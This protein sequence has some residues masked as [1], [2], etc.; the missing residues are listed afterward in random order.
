MLRLLGMRLDIS[1]LAASA[2][3]S[4]AALFMAAAV[5]GKLI[6]AW[7]PAR[8]AGFN[9]R[10]WL[11]I[12]CGLVP[13]GEL[14]LAVAT[15]ALFSGILVP[16][17]QATLLLLALT[18]LAIANPLLALVFGSGGHGSREP[19]RPCPPQ[20]L[21][22][23]FAT[24]GAPRALLERLIDV[25]ETE[26]FHVQLLNRHAA[27]YQLGKDSI[28]IGLRPE[29]NSL[30]V[31]CAEKDQPLINNAM[32]EVLAGIENHLR[33]LRQPLDVAV[34]RSQA[35]RDTAARQ[36][37][38]KAPAGLINV[39]TLRPRLLADTKAAAI[40]ELIELLDDEGLI[41]D[42]HEALS[43]VIAREEGMSTGLEHGIAMPHA[44]TNAVDHLVC[45]VGIKPEGID[46][47]TLDNSPARIV[48]LLLA[49]VDA[50]APQLQ[51]ISFFSRILNDQG[52]AA[53][54]ACDSAEDMHEVLSGAAAP[55]S[56]RTA[57]TSTGNNPLACLQWHSVTLDLQGDTRE[58]VIDQLLALCAR[59]GAVTDLAEARA[60]LLAAAREQEQHGA[61]KRH[62]PAP[63][64]HGGG[65]ADGLRAGH[66]P[67]RR[68][69]RL[70]RRTA[71][72]NLLHGA[73][74]AGGH[75]GLPPSY[76]QPDA[77]P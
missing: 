14:C 73:H 37:S 59:S 7:L 20:Q 42:R 40:S 64:T 71:C 49:P 6:G 26:G 55:D 38:E 27:I 53:L 44:R 29:G 9:T 33:E 65:L 4:F 25:L 15:F 50:P 60:A 45:A 5:V 24:P 61:G 17:A 69:F 12:G 31:D 22:F 3:W 72:Q 19:D 52:R 13:R 66:Q 77:R 35:A 36:V 39:N 70:A 54:L 30:I 51:A 10:G 41:S 2:I 18:T 57:A 1:A 16:G 63:R 32:V 21:R 76:R 43:A 74:P 58:A 67:P 47:G 28:V 62:R 68:G 75:H 34:L 23:T 11:R 8:L 56:G 46:F 48:I